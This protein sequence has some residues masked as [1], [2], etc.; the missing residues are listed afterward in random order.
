M[1]FMIW[2]WHGNVINKGESDFLNLEVERHNVE[3]W[4]FVIYKVRSGFLRI[5]SWDVDYYVWWLFII[6]WSSPNIISSIYHNGDKI[7]LLILQFR[8]FVRSRSKSCWLFQCYN[9]KSNT[10]SVNNHSSNAAEQVAEFICGLTELKVYNGKNSSKKCL[11]KFRCECP[12]TS[13]EERSGGPLEVATPKTTQDM[14]WAFGRREITE[15]R[16]IS[17]KW[18]SV[19]DFEWSFE[20][21]EAIVKIGAAFYGIHQ[22]GNHV[23]TLRKCLGLLNRSLGK[24]IRIFKIEKW[25]WIHHNTPKIKQQPSSRA[26]EALCFSRYVTAEVGHH[27]SVNS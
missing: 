27:G 4:E 16:G 5:K 3:L 23:T 20:Y 19:F 18:F 25:K 1:L 11:Y 15:I 14:L 9:F 26:A 7:N 13:D 21:D 2:D 8:G 24:F 22:S 6:Q 17:N 10:R 12:C